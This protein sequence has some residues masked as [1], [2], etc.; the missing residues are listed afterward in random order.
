MTNSTGNSNV[1]STPTGLKR[2]HGKVGETPTDNL[3]QFIEIDSDETSLHKQFFTIEQ[4]PQSS[5]AKHSLEYDVIW[6]NKYPKERKK[7]GSAIKKFLEK[8]E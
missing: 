1:K 3:R 6:T 5:D 8:N 7:L 2:G 4:P